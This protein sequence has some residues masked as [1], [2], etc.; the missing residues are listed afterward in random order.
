MGRLHVP[1]GCYHVIGRGL[2]RRYI[3]GEDTDKLDFLARL[4]KNLAHSQAQCLAWAIMSN[5]YHLLV[6]VSNRPLSRLMA[7]L[8]GGYAGSYNRRHR[9]SGYVF[10][11]RYESILCDEE[12]YLL[13]LIRYIHLNRERN[14]ARLLESAIV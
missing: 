9:R 3:F 14:E 12:S 7:P 6:R 11:N 2:E 5:H 4:G 13:E 10:Q 1:G 8:L